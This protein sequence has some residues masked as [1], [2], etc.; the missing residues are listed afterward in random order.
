MGRDLL[1]DRDFGEG[2]L[3]RRVRGDRR[4]LELKRRG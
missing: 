4:V 3:L 1:V 2:M